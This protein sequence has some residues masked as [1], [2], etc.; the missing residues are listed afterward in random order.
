MGNKPDNLIK[1]NC[2]SFAPNE[3]MNIFDTDRH[4]FQT[5]KTDKCFNVKFTYENAGKIKKLL[6]DFFVSQ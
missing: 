3:Y 5:A 1:N 6:K 2:I 4:V